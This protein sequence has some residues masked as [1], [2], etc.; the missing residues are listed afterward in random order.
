MSSTQ[1]Q[2]YINEKQRLCKVKTNPGENLC[3]IHKKKVNKMQQDGGASGSSYNDGRVDSEFI[4]PY[5]MVSSQLPPN[6]T[7]QS[8]YHYQAPNYQTFGDYVCIKKS[9][10]REAKNLMNEVFTEVPKIGKN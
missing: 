5:A 8:W 3:H 1:C 7:Q 6:P 4:S 2:Y 10:L 9:F